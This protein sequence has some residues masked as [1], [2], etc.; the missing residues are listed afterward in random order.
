M[1]SKVISLLIC[2]CLSVGLKAQVQANPI[3]IIDDLHVQAPSFFP[4]Q[5]MAKGASCGVDTLYYP[6]YKSS[7]FYAVSLNSA[8][9]GDAFA[10]WYPAPQPITIK[11][12]DFFAYQSD[13]TNAS[14]TI[15]CNLYLAQ[16]DSLPMSNPVRTATINIDSTFGGGLLSSLRKHISFANDITLSVPYVITLETQ[17]SVNVSVICNNYVSGDGKGEWLSHVRLQNNWRHGYQIN[18][19][20]YSLNADFIFMPNVAYEVKADFTVFGCNEGSTLFNFP[21]NSSAVLQNRFYNRYTY[22]GLP[23]YGYQWDY[24]DTSGKPYAINGS[25]IYKNRMPYNVTLRDTMYGWTTGC[26]DYL[27]KEVPY[28]PLPPALMNDGPKCSGDSIQLYS[29][30]ISSVSYSWT[31]PDSFSSVLQYPV[32][33]NIDTSMNGDYKLKVAYKNCVSDDAVMKVQVNQTPSISTLNNDGPKCVGDSVVFSASSTSPNITYRWTGPNGFSDSSDGFTFYSL[34]TLDVG[35]YYLF[36]EDAN[37]VSEV[38]ST[39]LY[40]YPPPVTPILSSLVGDSICS[41][42]SIYLKGISV[43]GAVFDWQGPLGFTSL[44]AYPSFSAIDTSQSGW[45]SSR[46]VIGSCASDRD[47]VYLSILRTPLTLPIGGSDTS[48]EKLIKT[49][50]SSKDYRDGFLWTCT[51]G[52]ILSMDSLSGSIQ[53]EWGNTGMGGL[54]LYSFSPDGCFG[55]TESY[56]VEILAVPPPPDNT[57]FVTVDSDLIA[58]YPNPSS[59]RITIEGKS[60]LLSGYSLRSIDGKELQNE[61]NTTT[62]FNIDL[63]SYP[64]GT[65]LLIAETEDGIIPLRI[66]L[67]K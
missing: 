64:A 33:R 59:G 17:S 66:Q 6:Y 25:H 34:D 40:T 23:Q 38:D 4:Q 19:G 32:L 21:T 1:G 39:I 2:L 47:S 36:V 52:T 55:G 65:Y 62:Q 14:V 16:G 54:T 51:G 22:Y 29:D 56:Q 18:I 10:Q 9:S 41:G 46:V 49:Y 26:V 44:K 5:G 60:M 67:V 20:T 27:T 28:R 61:R 30:S 7:A 24:G 3:Q 13:N 42:D 12:F 45:Y 15:T 63:S 11:G 31:G 43:V 53:V 37:C 35:T 57:G 8:T 50:T 48:T 58:V